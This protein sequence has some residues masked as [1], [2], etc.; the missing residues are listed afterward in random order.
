MASV[1]KDILDG[2]EMM[3][4][5]QEAAEREAAHPRSAGAPRAA[6]SVHVVDHGLL[7]RQEGRKGH[8]VSHCWNRRKEVDNAR[9]SECHCR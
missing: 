4:H 5:K 6:T 3:A 9:Q 8:R 1:L 7:Q 2:F